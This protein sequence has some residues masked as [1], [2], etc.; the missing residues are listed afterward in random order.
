MV[1]KIFYK[2]KIL[3]RYE[4]TFQNSIFTYFKVNKSNQINL[5]YF[6]FFPSLRW[7][8]TNIC[9]VGSPKKY[10]KENKILVRYET[11]FKN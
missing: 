2:N 7:L 6:L 8:Y 4:T 3:V 10:F 11:T 5:I 9:T 1:E